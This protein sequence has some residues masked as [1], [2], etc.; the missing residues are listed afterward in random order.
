[1]RI[2]RFDASMLNIIQNCAR[3]TELTF[4]NNLQPHEREESLEKGDLMHK[5]LE[6]YYSMKCD[7]PPK[8]D[9]G[10]WKELIEEAQIYPLGEPASRGV[11][12]GLFYASKMQIPSSVSQE[13]ID[14]FEAYCKYYEHDEWHPLKV[15]Q[16]GR[17]VIYEDEEVCMVYDYKVDLVAERGSI[18]APFDHKTSSMRKEP[19][20]L[21][22]QFIGYCYALETDRI[23]VN[24]IGFQK[25]LPPKDRFQRYILNIDKARIAEWREN[26]LYWIQ[27]YLSWRDDDYWPM[28][29][30]SCDKYSGCIFKRICET[31]PESRDWK[32]QKDFTTVPRW[33]VA[34]SLERSGV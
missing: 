25:S 18:I 5:M 29:L 8:R 6:V 16:V 21:S 17:Q 3:K 31:D 1:M 4:I 7:A 24:K 22:N 26:T 34:K 32:I 9:V 12:A 11:D 20:S 10:T 28:N 15:E 2:E 30:T 19:S 13:V 27:Q 33:D 14:Q 23:I